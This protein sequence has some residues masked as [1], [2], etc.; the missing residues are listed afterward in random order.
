MPK[1]ETFDRNQVLE[2]ATQVFHQKGYNG[3]SMQDL[4]DATSLNRSSIYNSFGNKL[5]MFIEVLAYYQQINTTD[6]NQGLSQSYNANE[7]IKAIFDI[8]LYRILNDDDR[9]GCLI[10]NCKSEMTNQEPLITSFMEKHQERMIAVLEDIVS[11]GQ[12][13]KVFNEKQTANQYALYLFTSIQ[14]LQMTGILNKNKED[15]KA[16]INTITQVLN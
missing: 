6:F 4:V 2:R 16:L 3:T 9:K 13:E 10:V 1:T 8:H 7:A 11:K 12:M 5:N 15:L 14:G